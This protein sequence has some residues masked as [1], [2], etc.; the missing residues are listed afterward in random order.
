[1]RLGHLQLLGA[2]LVGGE[3]LGDPPLGPQ[4]RIRTQ[5]SAH[6]SSR[7]KQIR[8]VSSRC[9]S[10]AQNASTSATIASPTGAASGGAFFRNSINLCVPKISWAAFI[11]SVIPSVAITTELPGSIGMQ[12]W[13]YSDSGLIPRGRPDTSVP[14]D[15]T[16]PCRERRSGGRCP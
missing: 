9:G 6:V 2:L 15:L 16:S 5:K 3:P 8:H 10:P 11:A 4:D 12:T 7:W 13:E 14:R 1:D